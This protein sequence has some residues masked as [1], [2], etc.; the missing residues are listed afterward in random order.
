MFRYKGKHRTLTQNLKLAS[1]LSFVAGIVNVAGYFS[2]HTLTTNVTG[3]VTFFAD[4]LVKSGWKVAEVSLLYIMSFF[5]GA[6]V[7]GMAVE[8]MLRRRER[9]MYLIPVLLEMAILLIISLLTRDV[10]AVYVTRVA[11]LLL[12]AMGMQNALVTSISNSVVRTTHLTGLFTDLGIEIGQLFF[13]R[14]PAQKK[15]LYSSI[16]LR[17]AIIGFFFLGCL[18][19]GYGYLLLGMP[20]LLLAVFCLGASLVYDSL[21]YR[22]VVM[23]RKYMK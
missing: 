22:V 9:F 4:E 7:S 13:Y 10:L 23:K 11:C 20:V 14:Q 21:R 17:L 15:R 19:G 2:I 8:F 18:A 16:Q 12:F 5:A 1:L 6:F 3:H